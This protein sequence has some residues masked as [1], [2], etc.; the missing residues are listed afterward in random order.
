MAVHYAVA[1]GATAVKY[2]FTSKG[3]LWF[4]EIHRFKYG[5][6][7]LVDGKGMTVISNNPGVVPN[8]AAVFKGKT[9]AENPRTIEFYGLSEGTSLIDAFITEGGDSQATLQ[10]HVVPLPGAKASWIKLDPPTA[11]LNASDTPVPY[12]MKDTFEVKR[13]EKAA[14]FL[15]K[16]PKGTNHLTFSCHGKPDGVLEIGENL[17]KSNVDAFKKLVD[18]KLKVIW[19]GGCSVAGTTQGDDFCKNIARNAKCYVVAPGI[20]LPPVKPP[21]GH[22]ELF[23]GSLPHYINPEG[24]LISASDFFKKHTDLGFKVQ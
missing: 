6:A 21:L 18:V 5:K 2:D 10:V 15:A 4:V 16:V 23:S 3:N 19:I 8:D 11:T 24:N 7:L 12:Q 14:D 20:T 1:P 9:G 22:V 17:D 13:G